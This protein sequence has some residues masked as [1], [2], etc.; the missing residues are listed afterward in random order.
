MT[1]GVNPGANAASKTTWYADIDRDGYGG[2]GSLSCAQ[3]ANTLAAGGDCDDSDAAINPD[4]DEVCNE[5]DDDCN[6]WTDDEDPGLD[7]SSSSTPSTKVS[8]PAA[9]LGNC[10]PRSTPTPP[11]ASTGQ[12]M[13]SP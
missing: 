4:M 7:L 10:E 2:S 5:V 13:T 6:G 1:I 3:P 8:I 11:S 9:K 12:L